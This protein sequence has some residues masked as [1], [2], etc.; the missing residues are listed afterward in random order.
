[1]QLVLVLVYLTLCALCGLMGRRTAV[2][3]LGHFLLAM[4][5]TPV[6]DLLVQLVARPSRHIR[7]KIAKL[8]DE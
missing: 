8:A 6:G 5:I 1:M 4:F 7:R 3:F 2:G